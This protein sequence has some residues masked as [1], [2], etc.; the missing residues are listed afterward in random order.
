MSIV[1][2]EKI[3]EV[4]N[5]ISIVSVLSRHVTLKKAG[6]NFRGLCP[7]HSEKSPS[8][9]VSEAKKIYH[10]F[11][12]GKGGNVFTFLME[13]GGLSFPEALR[14][15]AQEVGVVIPEAPLTTFQ[16][17]T[18][19][20]K[21]HFYKI[22]KYALLFFKEELQKNKKALDFFK[23]RGLTAET[24]NKYHLGYASS[25]KQLLLGFLKR[26]G[27]LEKDAGALGLDRFRD[28]IL[29]PLF[30][31]NQRVLGFGGRGLDAEAIPKYLN[32]PESLI[33][34]KGEALYGLSSAVSAIS[35]SGVIIVEGYF[36]C[37]AMHQV[38]LQNA[39]APMGTALTAHQ[40]EILKRFTDRFYIFFDHDV[41]GEQ[42]SERSLEIFLKAGIVPK[43]IQ[44][45]VEKDPD[46]FIQTHGKQSYEFLTQKIK[47]AVSLLEFVMYRILVRC[48]DLPLQKTKVIEE[49]IPY[50]K[51][52]PSDLERE[53]II[54][55]LSDQLQV[56]E[57]WI[58]KPLKEASVLHKGPASLW[59]QQMRDEEYAF[60]LEVFEF[61]MIFPQWIEGAL[62]EKT[63]DLFIDLEIKELIL[64]V[65]ETFK[66]KKGV[67]FSLSVE[68]INNLHLKQRLIQGVLEKENQNRTSEEWRAMYQDCV[69]RLHKKSL[70]RLEKNLLSQIKALEKEP[71]TSGL[72]E[73]EKMTLLEQYQKLAKQKQQYH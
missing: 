51:Q 7:F 3:A 56:E 5:R 55:K 57:K 39:V 72:Q 2:E 36:D 73:K 17:E 67:D 46:E 64:E 45:T 66:H 18:R 25:Q 4:R 24:L 15:C 1:S 68:K 23:K 59:K 37:L 9:V 52:L 70:E 27:I 6:I 40:V 53:E 43:V 16:K 42:A 60:E 22:N 65:A 41:A 32:S 48:Q 20:T 13:V 10:C 61:F 44:L 47:N 11:G 34:K 50:L 38:G 28:R 54:K 29:F 8:F 26:K 21:E 49:M 58:L 31:L 19:Q 62:K 14:K 12:C 63:L 35:K 33:Y 71:G 69:K 30:D